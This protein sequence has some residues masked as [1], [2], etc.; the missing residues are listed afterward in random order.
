MNNVKKFPVTPQRD[1]LDC[2][3]DQLAGFRIDIWCKGNTRGKA[4]Y[5][6]CANQHLYGRENLYFLTDH[7]YADRSQDVLQFLENGDAGKPR[8]VDIEYYVGG[9]KDEFRQLGEKDLYGTFNDG[10]RVFSEILRRHRV[11]N[12]RDTR[13]FIINDP[14]MTTDYELSMDGSFSMYQEL[15][16][17]GYKV[18]MLGIDDD[19]GI[20][21]HGPYA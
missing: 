2:M 9:Q 19:C 18:E 20:K 14:E 21:A 6:V 8:R 4:E 11:A 3:L 15:S 13:I 7:L 5:R 17:R 12:H 1:S 16:S 10:H